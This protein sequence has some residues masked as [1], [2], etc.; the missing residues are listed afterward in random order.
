MKT[1]NTYIVEKFKITKD[2]RAY[3]NLID[4]YHDGDLCLHIMI[5]KVAADNSYSYFLEGIKIDEILAL[6]RIKYH[7]ITNLSNYN[8]RE[9]NIISC[10]T[11]ESSLYFND[12]GASH[13]FITYLIPRH[14]IKSILKKILNDTYLMLNLNILTGREKDKK[15]QMKLI[16]ED[17]SGA[18][19]EITENDIKRLA[20]KLEIEL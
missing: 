6:D 15:I 1:I 17:K 11:K 10:F 16:G 14:N 3:E 13:S 19:K 4:M 5:V 20:K 9:N 2:T 7:Y 8:T 12:E 18:I